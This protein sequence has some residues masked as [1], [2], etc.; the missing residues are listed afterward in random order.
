MGEGLGRDGEW[1][2]GGRDG[3]WYTGGGAG[4]VMSHDCHSRLAERNW[5]VDCNLCT[6]QGHPCHPHRSVSCACTQYTC[7]HISTTRVTVSVAHAKH[8][9]SV[10]VLS[11]PSLHPFPSP[12]L[13]LSTGESVFARCLSSLKE[14]RTQASKILK[15]PASKF[16][17]DKKAFVEHVRRVSCRSWKQWLC[18]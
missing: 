10:D 15:G 6:G 2:G 17:E 8:H 1:W 14:E 9:A 16:Q 7:P 4:H 3:E 11:S 12:F 13:P 18:R 5:Q